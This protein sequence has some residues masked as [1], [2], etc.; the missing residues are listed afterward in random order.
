MMAADV[1]DVEDLPEV[2]RRRWQ[3]ELE[4]LAEIRRQELKCCL[5]GMS[6]HLAKDCTQGTKDD[7]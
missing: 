5:C 6:G 4:Q 3:Q 1:Q 2:A 7:Q